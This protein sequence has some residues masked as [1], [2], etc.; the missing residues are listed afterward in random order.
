M[1]MEEASSTQ[2][3][4]INDQSNSA[5]T[6]RNDESGNDVTVGDGTDR[7]LGVQR[8]G[9]RGWKDVLEVAVLS[10]ITLVISWHLM[11]YVMP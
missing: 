11:K 8:D 7:V 3:E 5:V 4:E 9:A 1:D 10:T 6:E 2:V